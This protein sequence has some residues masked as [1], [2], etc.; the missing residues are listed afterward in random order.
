MKIAVL[1]STFK[2]STDDLRE[3]TSIL[4]VWLLLNQDTQVHAFDPVGLESFKKIYPTWTVYKDTP[5]KID[6]HLQLI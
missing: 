4:N 1:G 5:E 2:P 6:L 3:T